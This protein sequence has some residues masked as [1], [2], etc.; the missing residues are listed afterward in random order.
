MNQEKIGKY[1]AKCRK[2]VN[3]TQEELAD[4]IGV[5]AKSVSKWECGVCL[6]DISKMQ[7]LCYLLKTNL[8]NLL[9]GEDSE[10]KFYV[11][12]VGGTLLDNKEKYKSYQIKYT[13]LNKDNIELLKDI[14]DDHKKHI[15]K[16]KIKGFRIEEKNGVTLGHFYGCDD[17]MD[18]ELTIND[19]GNYESRKLIDKIV[20]G[21]EYLCKGF[22]FINKYMSPTKSMIVEEFEEL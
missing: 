16:V 11:T 21:K 14:V 2:K 6:P 8:F 7:D 20:I 4:L 18:V 5:T 17:S 3:L 19:N 13:K 9:S 15:I 1:I 10:Y 12:K 22:V